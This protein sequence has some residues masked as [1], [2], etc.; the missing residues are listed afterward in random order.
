MIA[1][2]SRTLPSAMLLWEKGADL[3][4]KDKDGYS[5]YEMCIRCLV[6]P[7]MAVVE[8]ENCRRKN[9]AF[10]MVSHSR[11][12]GGSEASGIDEEVI[13]MILA[14]FNSR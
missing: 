9:E 4:L 6:N 13:K 3:Y 10:A 1:A 14:E 11:L 7:V 8:A 5:A 12:G 2:V